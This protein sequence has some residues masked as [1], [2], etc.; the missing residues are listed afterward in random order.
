M[1]GPDIIEYLHGKRLNQSII[2]SCTSDERMLEAAVTAAA[3][4]LCSN[5]SP[6]PCGLC[7]HCRKAFSGIHP[8][9][10]TIERDSEKNDITVEQIRKVVYD[11][12]ILPNEAENTVYIIK[13]AEEMNSNAQNA[14]LKVLE[15]PPAWVSFILL[16][17]NPGELLQTIRSRCTLLL[18][19]PGEAPVLSGKN[20]E[21]AVTLLE[22]IK[23]KDQRD[24]LS[25]IWEITELPKNEVREFLDALDR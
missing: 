8:D 16:A 24:I 9:V 11:A 23:S 2:I 6:D 5:G 18:L 17:K 25:H 4:K 3:A 20:E 12:S 14:L 1:P 21:L 22:S 13:H 19:P 7:S 15:E 10:I